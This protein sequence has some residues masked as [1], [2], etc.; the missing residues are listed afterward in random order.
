MVELILGFDQDESLSLLATETTMSSGGLRTS[1]KGYL[2]PQRGTLLLDPVHHENDNFST[3]DSVQ[4]D[5]TSYGLSIC[6]GSIPCLPMLTS[7][8]KVHKSKPTN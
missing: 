6:D 3:T 2:N 8:A 4:E 7:A 5:S 1:V